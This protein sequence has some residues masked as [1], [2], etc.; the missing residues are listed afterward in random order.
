MVP[1]KEIFST[2]VL[3]EDDSDTVYILRYWLEDMRFDEFYAKVSEELSKVFDRPISDKLTAAIRQVIEAY[4]EGG[5]FI[6]D[7][8]WLHGDPKVQPDEAKPFY[9]EVERSMIAVVGE[10]HASFIHDFCS[11]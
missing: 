10:K 8:A 9:E 11:Y 7:I 2:F 4:S 6:L 1:L 3:Q 5:V